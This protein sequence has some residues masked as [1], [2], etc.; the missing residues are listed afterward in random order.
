MNE[1]LLSPQKVTSSINLLANP[2]RSYPSP[3]STPIVGPRAPSGLQFLDSRSLGGAKDTCKVGFEMSLSK[4][5]LVQERL[6]V[7]TS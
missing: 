6:R 1:G 3:P 2:P 4:L 7:A 5:G